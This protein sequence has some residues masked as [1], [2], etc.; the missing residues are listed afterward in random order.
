V[1]GGD[2]LDR[3]ESSIGFERQTNPALQLVDGGAFVSAKLAEQHVKPPYFERM[4]EWNQ[5]GNAPL[6]E[7]IPAPRPLRPGELSDWLD[8]GVYLVD[9]RM[10]Q[11]FAAG[12]VPGS[13]NI[14]REGLSAYVGW[15][16]PV[17]GR[18]ALILPEDADSSEVMRTML[19]IG[20]DECVGHLAGGF[21]TW[22]DEGRPL[23]RHGTID[24]ASLREQLRG[25]D[26]PLILDV[27]Q[28]RE[29]T[30]DGIVEDALTIFL[31]DLEHRVDELPRNRRI[32]TMCSVGHRGGTAAS[33]L[34]KHGFERIENHLGGY[35]AWK[36]A[37]RAR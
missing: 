1:C 10:P 28:P 7:R 27:R 34:T 17:G 2:I 12:H 6:H 15:L 20:Y 21:E 14:W 22:Q 23:G 25:R 11:A 18:Y 4:E 32:V 16:I 29:W 33:I 36:A 5:R 3:D 31:G 8:D 26:R 13:Y 37:G 19:R 35:T 24:T 9:A 30:Q